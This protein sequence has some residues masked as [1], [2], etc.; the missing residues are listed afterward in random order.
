MGGPA[1][2]VLAAFGALILLAAA[3]GASMQVVSPLV[4]SRWIAIYR[5]T[6]E[7]RGTSEGQPEAAL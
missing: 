4:R 7:L 2:R 3:A 6:D 1:V 5:G